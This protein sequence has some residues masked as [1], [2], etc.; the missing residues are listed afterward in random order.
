VTPSDTS[1]DLHLILSAAQETGELIMARRAAGLTVEYKANNSPVTDADL[2]ADALLTDRLRTARPD[3]GWLSEETADNPDRL[4]HRRIFLVDP[5]DGTRAYVKGRPWFAVSIAVVEDGH[6]VAAVVLA[7]ELDETYT[8]TVG[9]GAFLNGVPIAPSDRTVLED[10]AMVGD[11]A[12]FAHPSWPQPWPAMR[13]ESRNSLALRICLV[14]AGAFDAT[15][16]PGPKSDW[17]L[18]AADLVAREAGATVCD[19]HGAL[20]VYNRPKPEQP[21]L[22]ACAPG[23]KTLILNRLR[24]IDRN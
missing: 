14:A 2:A 17:D 23:L 9:G 8:A 15:V 3:Y 16:S 4:A 12:M 7:P 1:G 13:I 22:V 6:P 20:F 21:G 24:P 19:R 11:K 5:I 10:S 18:G